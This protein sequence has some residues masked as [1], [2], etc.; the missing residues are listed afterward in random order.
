VDNVWLESTTEWVITLWSGEVLSIFADSYSAEG[1]NLVFD[2]FVPGKPPYFVEIALVPY[3]LIDNLVSEF[4]DR[5]D[6]P[7]KFSPNPRA[8]IGDSISKRAGGLDASWWAAQQARVSA[9][10][11]V[12]TLRSGEVLSIYAD[13]TS[14]DGEDRVFTIPAGDDLPYPVE[15]GR[16]PQALIR[17]YASELADRPG[18]PDRY[19]PL[20]RMPLAAGLPVP[21]P[22]TGPRD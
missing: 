14:L 2:V 12:V 10:E 11:W 21:T 22:P 6:A 1:E 18:A 17:D 4:A 3:A 13:S 19:P 9:T 7:D 8:R 15:I 16:V 5:P 20:P